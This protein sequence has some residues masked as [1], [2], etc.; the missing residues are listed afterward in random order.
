VLEQALKAKAGMSRAHAWA[1]M[2]AVVASLALAACGSSS[3]GDK[4]GTGGSGSA[5]RKLIVG[6]IGFPC[7]F[8][9]F[10]KS[11]CNGFEEGAKALPAG[12][13]FELKSGT[14]FSDQ[15]AFNNLIQTSL[16]LDPAGAI[17]LPGG[18]AAQVPVLKQACAKDVEIIVLDNPVEGLG[19]CLSSY[20]AANNR[21]LGVD[22]ANWL[23]AHPPKSREV[24][25]VTFPPGQVTSADD[26]AAGFK[27]TAEAAG[28]DVVATVATDFALDRTR[29]QVTNMLTAQPTLGAIFSISDQM[30]NGTA[31]AVA[32]SDRSD[33]VQ[34]TIDG[35][36]DAVRRIPRGL[37][38]DAA[39]APFF[40][41][42]QS[43]LNMAKILQ[44]KKV[45]PIVYEPSKIIDESNVEEYIAAG[46]LR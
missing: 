15:T 25:I 9:D 16:Q 19:D 33:I 17:V 31:Q 39:Q 10:S 7:G 2:A 37:S 27:E 34:L 43:V 45:P 35:S 4:S 42:K 24:G 44:G 13:E 3:D 38:A 32:A 28:F 1:L 12:F 41:G 6:L 14:D 5:D 36:L 29:T 8:N 26:R 23:K 22:V 21:Q 18:P 40:A 46:G 30:G 11:L 20:I